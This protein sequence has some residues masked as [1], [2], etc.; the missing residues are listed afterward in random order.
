MGENLN[1]YL[2]GCFTRFNKNSNLSMNNFIKK[3]FN[4]GVGSKIDFKKY[5]VVLQHL[6]QLNIK[7]VCFK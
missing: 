6:L 7:K 3:Y 4:L 5:I 2:T 1:M